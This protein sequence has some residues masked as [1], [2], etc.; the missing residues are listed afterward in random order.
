MEG[1]VTPIK[2]S[3]KKADIRDAS[4]DKHHLPVK[5]K[6]RKVS[7]YKKQVVNNGHFISAPHLLFHYKGSG[8]TGAASHDVLLWIIS[9]GEGTRLEQVVVGQ[10]TI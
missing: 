8:K 2:V 10:N 5:K 9:D 6:W 3:L 1:A 7:F 4:L